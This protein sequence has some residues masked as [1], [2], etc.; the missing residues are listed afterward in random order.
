VYMCTPMPL[1]RFAPTVFSISLLFLV[2]LLGYDVARS[3]N[4]IY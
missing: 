1:T 4:F 3:E 2:F